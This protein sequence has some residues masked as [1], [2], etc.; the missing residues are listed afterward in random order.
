MYNTDNGFF[1]KHVYFLQLEIIY[2]N[3]NYMVIFFIFYSI[4]RS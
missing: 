3:Y 2:E 4:T 1:I